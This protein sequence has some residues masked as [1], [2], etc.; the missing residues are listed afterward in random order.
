[1][2]QIEKNI[3][4]QYMAKDILK[5]GSNLIRQGKKY[6]A[7]TL[8]ELIII[9]AIVGIFAAMSWRSFV[10]TRTHAEV[11]AVC[12][13][14]AAAINQTRSYALTGKKMLFNASENLVPDYFNLI[15]ENAGTNDQ[16]YRIFAERSGFPTF[17]MPYTYIKKGITV[18]LNPGSL[19]GAYF[20]YSV[21]AGDKDLNGG[22]NS[23]NITNVVISKNSIIKTVDISKYR[24]VC[25]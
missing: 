24:A 22:A 23:H 19:S 18:Q 15:I 6:K 25:R 12:S 16:K 21:P 11:E 9:M 17:Y 10:K 2:L 4:K 5:T 1:M 13:E 14:I 8:L 7:F 3:L 20:K